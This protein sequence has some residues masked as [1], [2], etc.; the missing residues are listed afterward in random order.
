[1]KLEILNIRNVCLYQKHREIHII[2][3]ITVIYMITVTIIVVTYINCHE[4]DIYFFFFYL[5]IIVGELLGPIK[6]IGLSREA[7][8]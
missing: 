8:G 5:Q 1:M 7:L 3:K 6:E 4:V 2:Y